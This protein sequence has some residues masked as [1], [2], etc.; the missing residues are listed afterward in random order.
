[1]GWSV[2]RRGPAGCMVP[3][4]LLALCLL[5]G[6]P[7]APVASAG[8]AQATVS[9]TIRNYT[10][11]PASLTIA[12]GTT[13]RWTNLQFDAN[14]VTAR[15]GPVLFRSPQLRGGESFSFT[16]TA[17]GTYRYESSPHPFMVG[18]IVV[19]ADE[20]QTFPETGFAVEGT[21]L[22]Y[23]RAHGLDL[24]DPGSSARESL[25][26]FGFPIGPPHDETLDGRATLVQYF[27]R[28][29]FEYHPENSQPY[30][31]LLGQFGRALHPPD[32]PAA[33]VAGADYAAATGHNLSGRFRDFWATNGGLAVFGLP[34][35][36][37]FDERLAD[38]NTYRVQYFER[39]RLEYHPENAA[40][41][42]VLLGQFGR[43]FVG[44][45]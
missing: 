43:Q 25:A 7:F 45:R 33:P 37:E 22:R 1:M 44:G 4:L 32:P 36:E 13:V 29:R 31:V 5:I 16:F 26:L 23:W 38:G 28:A 18:E 42:D 34:L 35:S 14:D 24:G 30:D 21:F 41:Y 27:G 9:V 17:P 15:E 20:R 11:Q 2:K 10:Y 8:A 39:A 40:P 12:P 3:L 6:V 19:V